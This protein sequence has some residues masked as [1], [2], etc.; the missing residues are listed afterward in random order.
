VRRTLL[1]MTAA[2]LLL[3]G[4]RADEP[5]LLDLATEQPEPPEA[6]TADPEPAPDDE[7]EPEDPYA[8]PDEIDEAYVER[9]I[10][11]ILEVQDE[12]LR[13]ALQQEQGTLLDEELIALHFA[14]TVGTEREAALEEFQTYIDDPT[15]SD[16]FLAVEDMG[17]S[18]FDVE[19]LIHAEADRCI[20][21]IG[22]WDI[23]ALV[24]EAPPSDDSFAF[25]LS[26]AEEDIETSAGN[27]TPWQWRDVTQMAD[28]SGPIAEGDWDDLDYG[29]ALDN[30]CEEL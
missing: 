14:T 13:G 1:T 23:S 21:A 8:V 22:R 28:G 3:V 15:T 29:T 17:R 27:P 18:S 19:R 7:P 4:C 12:I 16:N 2:G 20:I 11:A 6:E 10:N 25:S 26:R 24:R 9:V 5:D 30:T